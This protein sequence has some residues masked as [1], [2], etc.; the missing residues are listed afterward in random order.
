MKICLGVKV[1]YHYCEPGHG[2]GP[3]D[4]LGTT[5]KHGLLDM[6]VLRDIIRLQNAYKVYLA[7]CQHLGEVG[8]HAEPS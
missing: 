6:L 8:K 4:G 3:P 1:L 2:K 7:A 5:I